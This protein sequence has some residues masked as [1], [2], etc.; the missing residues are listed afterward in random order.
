MVLLALLARVYRPRELVIQDLPGH[1]ARV[2][3]GTC[4]V[5]LFPLPQHVCDFVCSIKLQDFLEW[6]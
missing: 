1:D 6:L 2:R 3:A 4:E 5:I